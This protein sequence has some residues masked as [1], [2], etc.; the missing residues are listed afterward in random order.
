MAKKNLSKPVGRAYNKTRI[1]L[2]PDGDLELIAASMSGETSLLKLPASDPVGW[3]ADQTGPE[4]VEVR[5]ID[6][7]QI[8]RQLMFGKT[9]GFNHFKVGDQLYH[10]DENGITPPFDE[11]R[12]WLVR[13]H[14]IRLTQDEDQQP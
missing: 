8:T 7:P 12:E 6:R 2:G 1:K 4:T 14:V 5:I 10:L 9:P 3:T 11:P 13:G